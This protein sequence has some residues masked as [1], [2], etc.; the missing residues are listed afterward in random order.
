MNIFITG[1]KGF[2]ASNLIKRMK[3][4]DMNFISG[5][6]KENETAKVF[7]SRLSNTHEPC[8]VQNTEEQWKQFFIDNNVDVVIHN[9]AIV[10]T[11]VVALNDRRATLTNVDGT[12]I[13]CR[14]A[15]SLNIPVCYMGTTVIYDTSKYQNDQI[16]ETSDLAPKTYYGSLKLASE[17]VLRSHCSKWMIIRPLFAY[18]GEGDM[19][20]LI[21]K[22]IYA[23]INNKEKVDMFLDPTKIKDYMHV[24][25]YCDAVL[26]AIDKDMWNDDWNVAAETPLVV[27]EIVKMLC[28]TVGKDVSEFIQ[29]HP[30]TDYLGNH[31]LSSK[32]FRD[33]SGWQ[34]KITLEEGI[35]MSL[36]SIIKSKGYNPLKYLQQAKRHDVDLTQYY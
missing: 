29:W 27:G 23:A 25:D 21:A 16:I 14:V 5:M 32:K 18:G 33:T 1:E 30:Q 17:Y 9:A 35:Q 7:G 19:N 22:T 26:T 6:C 24:N 36:D 12:F 8:I 2:I 20:S 13:I 34:P 10:G 28:D 15:E 11:D 3:L 4:F 31:M